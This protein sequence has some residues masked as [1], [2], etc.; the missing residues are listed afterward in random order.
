MPQKLYKP[1]Q[2][3]VLPPDYNRISYVTICFTFL[4]GVRVL[5]SITFMVQ[6]LVC[7][8]LLFFL[9]SVLFIQGFSSIPSLLATILY[10]IH[11]AH[12]LPPPLPLL[13]SSSFFKRHLYPLYKWSSLHG[14]CL[15]IGD[16]LICTLP[17]PLTAISTCS[18]E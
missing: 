18:P 3:L 5:L 12:P 7:L 2:G 11:F 4:D 13:L 10:F 1:P 8:S 16:E 9:S 17:S 15:S 14:L 6:S